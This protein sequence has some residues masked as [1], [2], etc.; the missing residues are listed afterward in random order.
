MMLCR[1]EARLST[2]PQAV[3]DSTVIFFPLLEKRIS[4]RSQARDRSGLRR[5]AS[6]LT[7]S[8]LCGSGDRHQSQ[9]AGRF[10]L[11]VARGGTGRQTLLSYKF[12]SM[13]S[14]ADEL[15]GQLEPANEMRGPVFKMTAT[16]G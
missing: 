9:F 4:S 13:V 6:D 1:L 12:R 16:R 8:A 3:D 7:F 10:I 14:N 2:V 15:K 5:L 11:P